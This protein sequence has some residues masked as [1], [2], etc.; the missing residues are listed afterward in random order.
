MVKCVNCGNESD[1]K[2]CPACGEKMKFVRLNVRTLFYDKLHDVTH[3]ENTVL[4]TLKNLVLYPGL[5]VKNYINGAKK[6][7]V[8]PFRY[9]LS[10]TSVHIILF[11]WLSIRFFNYYAVSSGEFTGDAL[12]REKEIYSILN[13]K[14]NYFEFLFPLFFSIFFYLMYRKKSGVNYAESLTAA[15]YWTG[16]MM[17][18]AIIAIFM[19][20]IDIRLWYAGSVIDGLYLLYATLQFTGSAKF[21]DFVRSILFIVLSYAAFILVTTLITDFYLEYVPK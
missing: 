18:L 13:S 2:Y 10:V 20:F 5:T 21:S 6:N 19:S 16:T 11:R 7:I 14:L 8:K 1:G 17:G 12:N 3:W 9:F 4:Y 15:F